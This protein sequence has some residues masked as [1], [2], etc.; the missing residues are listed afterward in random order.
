MCGMF[1]SKS[2]FCHDPV[3][4]C[5]VDMHAFAAKSS[6]PNRYIL[7]AEFES[8]TFKILFDCVFGFGSSRFSFNTL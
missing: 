5:C 8:K 7:V 4:A 2:G 6:K 3:S 1:G